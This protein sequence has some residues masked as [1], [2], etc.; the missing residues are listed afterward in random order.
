MKIFFIPG[1]I[2]LLCGHPVAAQK[3]KSF[4]PPGTTKVNDTMYVDK[5][6]VANIHWREYLYYLSLYD[7][8]SLPGAL[9]DTTVWLHANG[10]AGET[11][12]EYYFRHPGFN[13]Y[14]VVGIS[15]NQA[16]AFCQWR[17]KAANFALYVKENRIRDW[18]RHINDSFPIR[19]YYRLPAKD[20]WESLAF[21]ALASSAGGY[22][23][24]DGKLK[25]LFNTKEYNSSINVDSA[26]AHHYRAYSFTVM[27]TS[28]LPGKFR[29]YNLT[30]NVAEMLSENGIAKGGSF[31]HT[32]DE[33]DYKKNQYY[34]RPERWLGFRCVAVLLK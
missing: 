22:K 18:Q 33:S 32:L 12:S 21:P 2:L 11:Y 5:T 15:Y 13:N 8:A 27:V 26:G 19:F 28:F 4:S 30:G 14:P 16:V 25:F 29:T 20:E 1:I 24:K 23:E 17:T 31:E 6:E 3:K 34:T 9:P 7:S 10:N